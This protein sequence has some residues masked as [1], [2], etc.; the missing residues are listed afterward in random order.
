MRV[1]SLD[2]VEVVDIVTDG[3][4]CRLPSGIANM[5]DELRTQRGEEALRHGIVPTVALAAHAPTHSV[6]SEFGAVVVARVGAASVR[7]VH[8]PRRVGSHLKPRESEPLELAA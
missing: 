3:R 1:T 8:E 6:F 2:V 7:V 4:R 5:L